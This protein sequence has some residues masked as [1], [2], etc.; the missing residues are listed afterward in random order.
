M[1]HH[2]VQIKKFNSY[3]SLKSL[4]NTL[5]GGQDLKEKDGISS[6]S[7]K[8]KIKFPHFVKKF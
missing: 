8:K 1:S 4:K 6:F 5:V 2:N 7:S 3:K